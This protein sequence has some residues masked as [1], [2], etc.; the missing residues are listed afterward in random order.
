MEVL[1]G[2]SS[3]CR[4]R[5]NPIEGDSAKPKDKDDKAWEQANRKTIGLIQ[6]WIDN[7]IYHHV[8]QETN[9]K[10]LWD[11]LVNLYARKTPQNEA[12]LVKRLIHLRYRDGETKLGCKL[13]LKK[14]RHVLEIRFNLISMGQLDDEGYS[15]EFSGG[16]WKLS[17]GSLIVALGQKT[18]ILYKL[19][20]RNKSDQ[21]TEIF[22]SFHVAM[23]RETDIKLKCVRTDNG[24]EYMGPFKNYCRTHGIKLEKTVLKT[25]QQNGLAERMNRT[26]VERVHCMLFQ[27]KLSKSFWG[28]AMRAAVDLINFTPSVALDGDE[29]Q[30]VWIGKE[31]SYKHLKV[32]GCRASVY[33]P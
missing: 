20:A 33:I 17:K 27:A 23:E 18:D 6:Q 32:F 31:V 28:E 1:D 7:S 10:V 25:P 13:S 9:A 22:K 26:I 14:L 8:V 29:S 15:N 11:K 21:V 2:R 16:R 12:F 4:D 5:Y 24:D 30:H 19:R 3:I